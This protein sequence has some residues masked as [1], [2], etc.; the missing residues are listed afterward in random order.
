MQMFTDEF[1]G[2]GRARPSTSETSGDR[3]SA[4][5]RNTIVEGEIV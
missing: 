5:L 4:G 3:E 2:A 1:E